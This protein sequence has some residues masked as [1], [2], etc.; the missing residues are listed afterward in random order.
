MIEWLHERRVAA[1]MSQQKGMSFKEFRQRFQTEEACEAYLF[2]QRWPEGFVCP[3]CGGIG[4][5]HLHE[6]REYVCKQCHR[7]SSVTA[8]TVLHRTHLPL[9]VWFWA[10]Y[11]TARD[12]RGISAVQLSQELEIAYSSAWYLLHRLRAAMGQ[13]DQDYVLSGIVE[14]DDAY[15]GAP[16]SNGKRGRGTDKASALAVVSL[17]GQGHPRFLKI[18]ISKLDAE[19]VRCVVQ[20]TVCSGSEI[21]SDALGS[22]RAALREGYEHHFQVFDRD[23][24]AL[25]WVHTL[26][27]NVKSFLLGTYHGIGKKHLQSYFDEF[28]FRFNRRFWPDQLFPRFVCAVAASDILRYDDL[29]R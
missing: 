20:R 18:Q 9:T 11:L 1:K 13:R 28:A 15:F 8:G 10:I 5:Y 6:R 21:H 25:R 26:I 14:L 27:S 2:E 4:C 12:K 23:S 22:F 17:T 29:T 3:K 24:G 19:S 7:Q 16:K